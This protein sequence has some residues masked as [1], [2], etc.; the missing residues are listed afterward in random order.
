MTRIGGKRTLA[1][2]V[3][4][5]LQRVMALKPDAL[6]IR[7]RY[8][9]AS[10]RLVAGAY[11]HFIVPAYL[12]GVPAAALVA[13]LPGAPIEKMLERVPVFSAWFLGGYS[14]L[15]LLSVGATLIL[16]PL[17]RFLGARREANDPRRTSAASERRVARAIIDAA[18][19]L[20]PKSA[21]AL[22]VIRSPGWDHSDPR[23]QALSVDFAV[24]VQTSV[25]AVA[26]AGPER[27]AEF[28]E[29]AAGSLARIANAYANLRA[30]RTKLDEGDAHTVARYIE[31][32]YGPSDFSGEGP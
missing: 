2:S 13:T 28:E 9:I 25:A 22:D 8:V 30:E 19:Y 31:S 7:P 12:I 11:V 1:E 14:A 27:R 15:A 24:V 29:L 17:G 6:T 20:G 10:W 26:S 21:S 4:K 5:V 18:R 23:C 3:E 32:R 16:E